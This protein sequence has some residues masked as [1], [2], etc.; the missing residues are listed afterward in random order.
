MKAAPAV[1]LP[2]GL[3]M[4]ASR[5]GV[6]ALMALTTL[7]SFSATNRTLAFFTNTVSTAGNSFTVG[8]WGG[9]R[10]YLHN[11]PTPP[12]RNTR[13]QFYTTMNSTQPTA[14]TLYNYDTDCSTNSAGRDLQP[15]SNGIYEVGVCYV[16]NWVAPTQ[17]SALTINGQVTMSVWSATRNFVTGTPG[18]LIGVLIDYDVSA[19]VAYLVTSVNLTQSNWQGGSNTWVQKTLT[20][21]SV[22]RTFAVGHQLEV[23]LIASTD[24]PQD[25]W[26]AYDTSTYRTY[27]QLP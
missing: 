14:A 17:T 15:S 1:H 10:Y 3:P 4:R 19:N 27:L 22:N 7:V 9:P 24:A 21:P 12:T 18:N 16:A 5:F 2:G 6:A 23:R 25:M 11:N 13:A 20:F 8:T 26:V